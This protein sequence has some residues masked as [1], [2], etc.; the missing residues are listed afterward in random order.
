[1]FKLSWKNLWRNPRRTLIT[2]F[3]V[4]FAVFFLV[5]MLSIEHGTYQ[6]T[7]DYSTE[8]WNGKARIFR[9]GYFQRETITKSFKLPPGVEKALNHS[10]VHWCRRIEGYGLVS[11]KD[12]TYGASISGVETSREFSGIRK[13]MVQGRFLQGPGEAVLGWRLAKNLRIPLG[14][15]IALLVQG[16]D[17]SLGAELYKVVGIFNTGVVDLDRGKTL[18]PLQDADR[19]F[20]M[21][22]EVTTVAIHYRGK[23]D[24]SPIKNSLPENLELIPWQRIMP[25][26]LEMIEFDRAGAYIMYF[27]LLIVVIFGLLN[28]LYMAAFERRKEVAVMR[29]IGIGKGR[30][31]R[32]MMGEALF[33][34]V[35]GVLIGEALAFPLVF[36]F[37][38]NP[39]KISGEMA[40][41]YQS[42]NFAPVMPTLLTW[43]IF[44]GV[45]TLVCLFALLASLPPAARVLSES[46][47]S[48]LR[49]EK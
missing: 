31:L 23:K 32:I 2:S 39:I 28:T 1:M 43:K 30:I 14:E 35:I 18:I 33:I 38:R 17:G 22:G 11:F 15:K 21:G 20:S 37:N 27:I 41:V 26:L 9:K 24:L 45:G 12:K 42:L 48:Q 5:F 44:V 34:S 6:Y 7:K 8:I 49:F 46:L 36:Y 3:A 13:R 25:E 16:R 40:E 47:V 29:A 19:L 4:G 10:R